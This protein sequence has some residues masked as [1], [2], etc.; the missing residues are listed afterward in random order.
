MWTIMR[1]GGGRLM[2]EEDAKQ[3]MRDH[4][5]YH[6]NRNVASH[7]WKIADG[8]ILRIADMSDGHLRNTIAFINRIEH[9]SI[10]YPDDL[11]PKQRTNM[12][13]ELRWR[14]A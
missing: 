8:T 3:E 1:M 13:K 10:G 2:D 5:Q 14:G 12:E 4:L 7:H 6:L 9:R 11:L